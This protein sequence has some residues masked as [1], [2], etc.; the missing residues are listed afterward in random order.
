[1][2]KAIFYLSIVLAYV[3][4]VR[5]NFNYKKINLP[6]NYESWVLK[7]PTRNLKDFAFGYQN[8]FAD[9]TY[10]WAIQYFATPEIPLEQRRKNL[11]RFFEAIWSLDPHYLETYSIAALIADFDFHD[12][13]LAIKFLL[14][15]FKNNPRAVNLLEEAAYYAFARKKDYE[16]AYKLYMRAYRL[17]HDPK[18]LRLA[19]AML[20]KGNKLEIS[21]NYWRQVYEQA[22]SEYLKKIAWLHLYKIKAKI[23]IQILSEK[24]RQFKEKYGRYP[25]FLEELVREGLLREIPKDLDGNPYKYDPA[26]GEVKPAKEKLWK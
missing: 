8:L 15:G 4:V 16:L 1:M 21:W 10:I 6:Y 9:L 26:T 12:P 11:R 25:L 19:A 17:N 2:R 18:T 3:L 7:V 13:D 24:I 14:E 20:E 22:K 23:D 5:M